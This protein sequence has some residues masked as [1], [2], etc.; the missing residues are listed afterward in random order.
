MAMF[1]SIPWKTVQLRTT[2]KSQKTQC[3]QHFKSVTEAENN[4]FFFLVGGVKIMWVLQSPKTTL[5][6]LWRWLQNLFGGCTDSW[7]GLGWASVN[8]FCHWLGKLLRDTLILQFTLTLLFIFTEENCH[9]DW[10]SLVQQ[11]RCQ[12]FHFHCKT[13]KESNTSALSC[14]L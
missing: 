1:F 11:H 3:G 9:T 8:I 14:V 6:D 10:G 13:V 5:E 4:N 2:L 7:E 12:C